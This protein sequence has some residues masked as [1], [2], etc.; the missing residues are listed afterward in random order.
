MLG[1]E[2]GELLRELQRRLHIVD[3]ARPGDDH[4]PVVLAVEDRLHLGDTRCS[5]GRRGVRGRELRLD[6]GGR[7]ERRANRR[8]HA[9]AHLLR[10]RHPRCLSLRCLAASRCGY[11]EGGAEIALSFVRGTQSIDRHLPNTASEHT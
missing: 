5:G 4:E 1:L 10:G 8:L 3:R 6:L 7:D 2:R 11:N 9:R